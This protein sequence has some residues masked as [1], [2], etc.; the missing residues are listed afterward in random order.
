MAD[1]QPGGGGGTGSLL[2]RKDFAGMPNWVWMGGL[3]LLAIVYALWQRNKEEAVA[4]ATD[5]QEDELPGDQT[6]PPIFILP[7]NPQPTVPINITIPPAPPGGGRP[8]PPVTP[9]VT[10][11]PVPKPTPPPAPKG[12][13]V[14]ITKWPDKTKPKESTL[15]D[16]ASER[17]G[18]GSKWPSIWNASENAAL[19]KKRGKPELIRAGDRFWVPGGK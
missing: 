2:T 3:L 15:W 13:W 5:D 4:A 16:I 10:P 11:A 14:T 9:P 17:L 8:L 1:E 18:S 7:Q 6:A 12:V 19:K